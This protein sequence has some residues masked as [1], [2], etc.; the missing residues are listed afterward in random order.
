MG[1]N[2]LQKIVS[3]GQTGVDRGGLDAAIFL[4]IPHGGWCPRGRRAED[5]RIP[6]IYQLRETPQR[7]YVARTEQNVIDSDGTVVLFR[8]MISGGTELTCRLAKKHLRPL[9]CIDLDQAFDFD[10][11]HMPIRFNQSVFDF[12]DDVDVGSEDPSERL[13]RFL[14]YSSIEV[15]NI[16]GPRES[17]SPG[18][19]KLA[20]QFLIRTLDEH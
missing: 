15:L 1:I 13:L 19:Q 3:G 11:D 18:I 9:L 10:S 4:D 6:L 12:G 7:D 20:E 8:G 2:G 5:G 17:G 16:A 14:K